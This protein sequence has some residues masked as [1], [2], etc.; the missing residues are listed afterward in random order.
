MT[1]ISNITGKYEQVFLNDTAD[2]QR[3]D[4]PANPA[5]ADKTD[6]VKND[7]VSLSDA[8]RDMQTARQAVASTPDIRTEKV[9]EIKQSVEDGRYVVNPGGVAEKMIGSIID[10]VL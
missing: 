9:S 2:K 5:E 3:V 1:N 8:S 6:R 10:E 7:K 4:A